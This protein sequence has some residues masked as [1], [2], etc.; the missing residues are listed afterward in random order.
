MQP[1]ELGWGTHE[2]SLP[3]I[4]RTHSTG[5]GAAIYLLSPGA[6]TRVRSLVSDA[7]AAIWLPRHP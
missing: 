7:R 2:K 3:D 1:A 4:G 6:N 5:C